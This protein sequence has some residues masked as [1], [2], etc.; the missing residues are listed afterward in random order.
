MTCF[1]F[2]VE[3]A[4][5]LL[6]DYRAALPRCGCGGLLKEELTK[7]NLRAFALGMTLTAE[8]PAAFRF[9]DVVHAT[10]GRTDQGG[11]Y[12][13][14]DESLNMRRWIDF[15]TELVTAKPELLTVM[16]RNRMPPPH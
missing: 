13:H 10:S 9:Q 3:E 8:S 15:L 7:L 6:R 11:L 14:R 4:R 1:G 16:V 5:I 12:A 2:D